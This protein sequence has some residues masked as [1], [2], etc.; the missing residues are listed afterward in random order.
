MR[1]LCWY[2]IKIEHVI[3]ELVIDVQPT[4]VSIA[5]LEDERLVEFQKEARNISFAVGDIYLGKI[6]KLMPG[7]NAAFIDVGHPKEAFLHYADLGTNFNRLDK[8]VKAVAVEKK[9]FPPLG[10]FMTEPEVTKEGSLTDVLKQF[11]DVLVQIVKEPISTK[12]PRVSCEISYAGRYLVAMPFGD[13]VNVSSKIGSSEERVRLKQLIQSIKP[14]NFSV[15][16]RTSAEGKRVA[17]LDTELRGLVK[18]WN[19]S[20]AK[21]QKLKGPALICEETGRTVALLRDIFS[22]SFEHIYINDKE[23]YEEIRDYVSLIA[24]D[25]VPIV[26]HYRGNMPMLDHF[27]VTRQLRSGFGRTVT[28]KK[29]AYL[30]VEHTEAMH[31]IDVNSGNRKGTVG[32]E[33]TAVEVNQAAALEIAR[34]L[35]MRDM[36]GIIAVDFIDMHEQEN[37]Q[38]LLETMRTLMD[39]DR[40]KHNILPL[41]KFGVMMITRQR[42]RPILDFAN[43]E[44]CPVCFGTGQIKPSILFEDVL[45]AKVGDL[46]KQLKV[47][48][49]KL[50]VHPFVA[51]YLNQGFFTKKRK[52]QIKFGTRFKVVPD[53]SLGVLEYKFF[54]KHKIE[55][56]MKDESLSAVAQLPVTNY[57]LPEYLTVNKPNTKITD[58]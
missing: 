4:E 33:N 9:R 43:T 23:I 57:Q 36:G 49:F 37:R 19:D 16:V 32:Q 5:M 12:G 34:Q 10:K 30:I 53:Q 28:L 7:L 24:P 18:R 47:K 26:E 51:A 2:N 13:K 41:N 39:N 25:R 50:H 54:D 45:E 42:V 8:F 3:S 22:P 17:E 29:G 44:M 20:M 1:L 21:V 31:V 38:T 27:N 56:D 14:K 58:N 40:A 15:I 55:L 35:R 48:N 6:R 46:V 11:D 52:W